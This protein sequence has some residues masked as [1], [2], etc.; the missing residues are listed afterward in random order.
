MTIATVGQAHAFNPGVYYYSNEQT[1]AERQMVHA[2]AARSASKRYHKRA[3]QHFK[4]TTAALNAGVKQ[5]H[6]YR[7]YL[8]AQDEYQE[9]I[10]RFNPYPE[11]EAVEDRGEVGLRYGTSE[12]GFKRIYNK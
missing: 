12:T 11:Y 3:R 5:H 1:K 2:K 10:E 7:A 6:A 4:R 8:A 9:S